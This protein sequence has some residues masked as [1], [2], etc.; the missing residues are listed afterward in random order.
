MEDDNK[1]IFKKLKKLKEKIKSL[2]KLS[3]GDNSGSLE[4]IE[5][6]NKRLKKLSEQVDKNETALNGTINT[7]D[8]HDTN[9]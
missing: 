8:K 4:A 2:G 9:I 1:K 5:D 3:G 6:F 7:V